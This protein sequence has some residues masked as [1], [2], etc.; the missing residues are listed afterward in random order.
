MSI[1]YDF[2]P[3]MGQN[4][5]PS[6]V[7][8]KFT[9][10]FFSPMFFSPMFFHACCLYKPIKFLQPHFQSSSKFVSTYL[11][12][13]LVLVPTTQCSFG[14]INNVYNILYCIGRFI[15]SRLEKSRWPIA[16]NEQCV[17]KDILS[18]SILIHIAIFIIEHILTN[19]VLQ[20]VYVISKLFLIYFTERNYFYPIFATTLPPFLATLSVF[21]Y[22]LPLHFQFSSK[23]S[24]TT[25]LLIFPQNF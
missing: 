11:T 16:K 22:I 6:I 3:K 20:H 25:R 12:F 2:W 13:L 4:P 15:R 14:K 24:K 23:F 1:Y 18:A 9:H 17:K 7:S 21:S 10:V 5:Y 8:A 19:F